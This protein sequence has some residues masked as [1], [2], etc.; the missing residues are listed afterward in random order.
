M[1]HV[2]IA[3][4]PHTFTPMQVS[5]LEAWI[6]LCHYSPGDPITSIGVDGELIADAE[7]GGYLEVND[8]GVT[9]RFSQLEQSHDLIAAA[10]DLADYDVNDLA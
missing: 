9:I 8:D 7:D 2:S 3:E 6:L 1:K 4:R 5:A 10:P